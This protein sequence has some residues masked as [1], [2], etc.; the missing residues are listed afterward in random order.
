MK[1]V[2]VAVF[3]SLSGAAHAQSPNITVVSSCGTVPSTLPV[4]TGYS[5]FIDVNGNLCSSA[6]LSGN[7]NNPANGATGSA[8]PSQGDYQGINVGGTLRGQTGVN[9]S[10]S[11]FAAQTDISSWAGTVLGAASNYG[12]S[13]GAVTVPGVNAFVTNT[14]A[15]SQSGT[16]TVGLNAGSQTIGNVG[17]NAGSQTIGNVGLNAGTNIIGKAG[18]DQTTDVTTNGVEIAPTAGAAAGIT[19]VV[20][21]A[22]ESG[23]VFKASAGNLYSAYVTTGSTAGFLMIFN[24][25]SAPADGA[26]TPIHCIQAPANQ[27]VSLSFNPGPAEVFSTGITAVFSTTG[28]FTK[29]ASAT[30]FFHGAVK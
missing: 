11:I 27:T 26:V 9:P 15:V 5:L 18:I 21:S 3:L 12:T 25:T 2:V 29:T 23:H 1:R 14:P 19:S 7:V 6:S 24:A 17:L 10:G 28:C 22:A 4:G 20:S 30:A 13:P 8:V 16:W